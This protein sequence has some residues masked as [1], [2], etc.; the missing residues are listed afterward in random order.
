MVSMKLFF[1]LLTFS[2]LLMALND[3]NKYR[4][5][6]KDHIF[7]NSLLAWFMIIYSLSVFL[8]WW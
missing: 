6:E 5:T 1:T 7:N 8:I 3:W 2:C 4:R